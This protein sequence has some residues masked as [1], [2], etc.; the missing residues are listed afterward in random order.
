LRNNVQRKRSDEGS[1]AEHDED[2]FTNWKEIMNRWE[3][4]FGDTVP[5]ARVLEK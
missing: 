5:K 2:L 4:R 3:E 1:E